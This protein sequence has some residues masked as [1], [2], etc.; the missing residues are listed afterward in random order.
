MKTLL[1]KSAPKNWPTPKNFGSKT[2]ECLK[3]KQLYGNTIAR[4]VA[5]ATVGP[6]V[7]GVV[8]IFGSTFGQAKLLILLLFFLLLPI[9]KN[10][11]RVERKQSPDFTGLRVGKVAKFLGAWEQ[12]W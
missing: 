10:K 3:F 12:T 9:P 8:L 1:P 5:S 6:K 2:S 11:E 7:L 4:S